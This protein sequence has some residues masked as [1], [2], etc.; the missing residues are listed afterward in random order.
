MEDNALQLHSPVDYWKMIYEACQHV[1]KDGGVKG[2]AS[3]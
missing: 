3:S 2:G 1:D